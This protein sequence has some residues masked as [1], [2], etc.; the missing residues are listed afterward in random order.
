M[1]SLLSTFRN[2]QAMQ[3]DL[4]QGRFPGQTDLQI[5]PSLTVTKPEEVA[6]AR[7]IVDRLI[8]HTPSKKE[9]AAR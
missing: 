3:A 4:E 6:A 7:A 9:G 2:A 5:P 1:P 8:P